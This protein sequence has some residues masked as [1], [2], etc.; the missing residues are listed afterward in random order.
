[1]ERRREERMERRQEEIT[2]RRSEE[3][4]ESGKR[5]EWIGGR[6]KEWAGENDEKVEHTEIDTDMKDPP[7]RKIKEKEKI[8]FRVKIRDKTSRG[9]KEI[10]KRRGE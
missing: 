9:K 10:R 8:L 4:T 7:K 5:R 1:M 2:A 3:R 6:K